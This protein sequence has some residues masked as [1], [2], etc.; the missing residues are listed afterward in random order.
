MPKMEMKVPGNKLCG[1]RAV[2]HTD[3]ESTS[4]RFTAMPSSVKGVLNQRELIHLFCFCYLT[5]GFS[6]VCFRYVE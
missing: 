2:T 6:F 3:R 1:D 5:N 4:K